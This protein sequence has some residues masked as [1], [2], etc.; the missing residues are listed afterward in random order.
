MPVPRPKYHY[1]NPQTDLTDRTGPWSK[2]THD[3]RAG[4]V[5]GSVH[6]RARFPGHTLNADRGAMSLWLLSIDDLGVWHKPEKVPDWDPAA[7][8]VPLIADD[9]DEP[10]DVVLPD[11]VRG[12]GPIGR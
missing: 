3:G 8:Y 4:W 10:D 12:P 7:Y 11:G 5:A 2:L 1:L 9:L 6:S